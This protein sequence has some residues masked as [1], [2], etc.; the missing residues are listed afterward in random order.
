MS[1]FITRWLAWYLGI[2]DSESTRDG[3]RYW[4]VEASW[5]WETWPVCL[6]LISAW[7]LLIWLAVASTRTLPTSTRWGCRI[8]RLVGF[9]LLTLLILQI[10]L[11]VI[12]YGK[13]TLAVLV[14]VSNSM[15][16]G[17]AGAGLPPQVRNEFG[18]GTNP[19]TR[20]ELTRRL[21]SHRDSGAL[22]ELLDRYEL[23][24]F[25]FDDSLSRPTHFSE[26]PQNQR[27]EHFDDLLK[28]A[29][30]STQ[31]TTA[32]TGV[33][34]QFR[35]R[36]LAAILLLS[37]GQQVPDA[38]SRQW[39]LVHAQL[40]QA[41]C[42]VFSVGLGADVASLD[43]SVQ[44]AR[45]DPVG[46]AG[47]E[48]TVQVELRCNQRI[49]KPIHVQLS[50]ADTGEVADNQSISFDGRNTVTLDLSIPQLEAGQ[51]SLR[52]TVETLEGEIDT[53]NNEYEFSVIGREAA[54]RV[55]LIDHLPR[56][57]Y[58]RLKS[59]LERDRYVNLRTFLY[60]ADPDH[61]SED[62]TAIQKLPESLED[63]ADY[64]AVILGELPDEA[65]RSEFWEGLQKFVS[66]GGGLI[67]INGDNELDA[68]EKSSP[69]TDILP[70]WPNPE[71]QKNRVSVDVQFTA[72]GRAQRVLAS[73]DALRS[74]FELPQVTVRDS[75][76]SI[77]PAALVWLQGR[78]QAGHEIPLV[79][80]LRFGA[81]QIVQ[82]MCDQTWRWKFISNGEFYRRYWL[83]L[84]RFVCK[85]RLSE[86]LPRVELRVEHDQQ[87][88]R[89]VTVNGIQRRPTALGFSSLVLTLSHVGQP[90]RI[91]EDIVSNETS[92][93]FSQKLTHLEAG[94]Y[95]VIARL[96]G[97]LTIQASQ[98]FT[99][100]ESDPEQ[101]YAP[102]NRQV[103]EELS[104]H[105]RG[106]YF[107]AGEF[108]ECLKQLPTGI[109]LGTTA[110]IEIP[111]WRRWE[112]LL[113]TLLCFSVDWS[114]QRRYGLS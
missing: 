86:Q 110:S 20:G 92:G 67:V 24:V 62:R 111:L 34:D 10:R 61:L 109:G 104:A 3:I 27:D 8:V 66:G 59:T 90:D 96:T 113:F 83:Q 81:G 60:S 78:T 22:E 54:L 58:R 6:G 52:V 64:D 71:S 7:V 12:T 25:V 63:F 107:S 43:V 79:A 14:D 50:N 48:A 101:A 73:T 89:T 95:R 80:S 46:F 70:L 77:N 18:I 2:P 99:V 75:E 37:D 55:L 17:D 38:S 33:L 91:F 103:L 16:T 74:G 82:Q 4:R 85:T 76:V 65:V 19:V 32:L 9:A 114:L 40:R 51:N 41:R 35:G 11:R 93:A 69:L 68:D 5:N 53:T 94:E 72:E 88:P 23:D 30:R 108:Q 39:E 45:F 15:Q 100:V 84:V 106:K 97:D 36:Q 13:P 98:N 44:G 49:D 28:F 47:S 31:L 102:V 105:S 26:I 21:M 42:P 29:G 56:W 1:G 87:D 57:E 112:L